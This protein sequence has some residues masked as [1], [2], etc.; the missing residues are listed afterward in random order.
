M[1]K[2]KR[3][4]K[5]NV[6]PLA[7]WREQVE[8]VHIP[9]YWASVPRLPPGLSVRSA[10]GCSMLL[11]GSMLMLAGVAGVAGRSGALIGALGTIV[12]G[13]VLLLIGHLT[14]RHR[15]RHHK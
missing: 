5:S 8:H 6:D 9:G 13:G 10:F 12:L 11:L 1:S 7:E 15:R 14:L 3:R 4:N 2:H